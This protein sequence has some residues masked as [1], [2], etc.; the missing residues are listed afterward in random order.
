MLSN[1]NKIYNY[2]KL[3]YRQSRPGIFTKHVLILIEQGR[4]LNNN[5]TYD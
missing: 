4:G 5:E 2:R 1:G 3:E